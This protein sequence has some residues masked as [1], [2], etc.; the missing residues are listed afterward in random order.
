MNNKID[1]EGNNHHTIN[2]TN[3]DF[4]KQVKQTPILDIMF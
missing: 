3:I 2:Q 1:R 4:V